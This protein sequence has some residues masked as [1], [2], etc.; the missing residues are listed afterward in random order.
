M[1][2]PI[3]SCRGLQPTYLLHL[4]RLGVRRLVV[5]RLGRPTIRAMDAGRTPSFGE[6]GT[7]GAIY[8]V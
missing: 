4:L 7:E 6:F 1:S 8:V 5:A 2:D 3:V